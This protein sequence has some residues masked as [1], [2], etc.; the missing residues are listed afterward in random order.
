MCPLDDATVLSNSH[1][2]MLM[3]P[4]VCQNVYAFFF[5]LICVLAS[6]LS[7]IL[8]RGELLT[9]YTELAA[10]ALQGQ[11]SWKLQINP[12][13]V[14]CSVFLSIAEPITNHVHWLYYTHELTEIAWE[15]I[16]I[17]DI[18]FP[19]VAPERGIVH[20]QLMS[21]LRSS[22]IK[23]LQRLLSPAAE[24]LARASASFLRLE[25]WIVK[26]KKEGLHFQKP[27]TP[28]HASYWCIIECEWHRVPIDILLKGL[29]KGLK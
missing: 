12:A 5:G 18:F 3:V 23:I 20:D 7:P 26:L 17:K 22:R 2:S 21:V 29:K 11:L 14:N 25:T 15:D 4:Y 9:I 16:S 27:G 1:L 6:L 19:F 8:P 13:V 24:Q 28:S 10:G